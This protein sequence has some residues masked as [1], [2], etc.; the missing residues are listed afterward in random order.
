M[1]VLSC[2]V[3]GRVDLVV[4]LSMN[5]R[6]TKQTRLVGLVSETNYFDEPRQT[7]VDYKDNNVN[8][9]RRKTAIH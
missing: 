4:T 5:T 8:E 7:M 3:I 1:A 6:Y 2:T 9:I